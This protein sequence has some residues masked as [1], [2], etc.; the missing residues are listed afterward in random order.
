ML[1]I[2]AGKYLLALRCLLSS[3]TIDK[4]NPVV[5]EQLLRFRHVLSS[6]PEPLPPN[7]SEIIESELSS[8]LPKDANL[9]KLNEDFLGPDPPS[10]AHAHAAVRARR[11]MSPKHS[12]EDQ[13]KLLALLDIDS[14]SLKDAMNG[15]RMLREWQTKPEAISEYVE[16][17]RSRWPQ[18]T[19]FQSK[20]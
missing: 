8:I 6:L 2:S 18:A 3:Y 4:S 13:K 17:A 15:L 12:E 5:H 7:I 9:N 14:A 16:K 20:G 1:T 11:V 19:V 10:I